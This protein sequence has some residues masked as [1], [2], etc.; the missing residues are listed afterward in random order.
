MARVPVFDVNETLL[1]LG[2]MGPHF[3]RVFGD[4]GVGVGWFEQMIQSAL[5]ATVTGSY[6]RFRGPCRGRAGSDAERAR[7]ELHEG[8]R[9]AV[10]GQ[11]RRLPAHTEGS[12]GAG[13]ARRLRVPLGR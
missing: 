5:V 9:E 7:V 11:M 2:A 6:R 3:E 10:T 1:D 12:G 4:A 13:A 8:D